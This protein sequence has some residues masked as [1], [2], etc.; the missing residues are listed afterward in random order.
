MKLNKNLGAGY[1]IGYIIGGIILLPLLIFAV[2]KFFFQGNDVE[3]YMH[4]YIQN[5]ETFY[6]QDYKKHFKF[7]MANIGDNFY[8][9]FL[10][11]RKKMGLLSQ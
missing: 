9:A 7:R 11:H 10:N 5:T 2:N 3:K 1:A 6:S 8:L 4:Q